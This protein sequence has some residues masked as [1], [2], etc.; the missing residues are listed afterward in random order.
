MTSRRANTVTVFDKVTGKVVA[1]VPT[2][3]LPG[4]DGLNPLLRRAYVAIS[5][6]D[7]VEAI[8]LLGMDVVNRGG[9]SSSGTVRRNWLSAGQED[10]ASANTGSDTVSFVDAAS[11]VETRRIQVGN[12][13]QSV[14]VDRAGRRAYVFNTLSNTISVL[15]IGTG[16]G[17][18]DR[19][20]GGRPGAR[21][22]Q[23]GGEPALRPAQ[24][25]PVSQRVRPD[26]PFHR[27]QGLRGKRRGRR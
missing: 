17:G 9:R 27:A 5:G 10:P 23:P 15:D 12:G 7:A 3:S 4:G 1:V 13:P 22:V 20:H 18:G 26:D 11:L 16:G 8:D 6:E 21:G 19:R 2:G 14:L 25:F 24:V